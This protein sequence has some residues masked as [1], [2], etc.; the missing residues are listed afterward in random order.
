MTPTYRKHPK[1]VV[2]DVK[3]MDALHDWVYQDK[4]KTFSGELEPE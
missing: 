4:P 3:A 2:G 1:K